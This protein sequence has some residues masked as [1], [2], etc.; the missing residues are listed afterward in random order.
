MSERKEAST[1]T[2]LWQRLAKTLGVNV[3]IA[4]GNG[5]HVSVNNKG[6]VTQGDNQPIKI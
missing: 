6:P 1:K 4:T 3:A 2:S 5:T